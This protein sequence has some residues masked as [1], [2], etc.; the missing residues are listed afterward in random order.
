MDP[1]GLNKAAQTATAAI[2]QV[3]KA[4]DDAGESLENVAN[5]LQTT[6]REALDKG[7]VDA[8]LLVNASLLELQAWRLELAE[9]RKMLEPLTR[10]VTI[11]PN[12]PAA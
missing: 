12:P 1:L 3:A 5:T 7:G 10:G 2:P 11:T 9:W 4:I 6:I 8:A